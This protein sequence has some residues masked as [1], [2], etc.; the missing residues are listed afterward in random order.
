MTEKTAMEDDLKKALDESSIYSRRILALFLSLLVYV[1]ITVAST[2]D[3]DLLTANGRVM[4]PIVNVEIPIS[5]F[6]GVAPVFVLIFHFYLLFIFYKHSRKLYEWNKERK[7]ENELLLVPFIFNYYDPGKK[8]N[9][10]L[11]F[12]IWLLIYLLPLF[13]LIYIQWI[14]L[15]Y[16]SIGMNTYHFIAI[17]I[18]CLLIYFL[19]NKII[20]QDLS[21]EENDSFKINIKR[22]IKSKDILLLL[23]VV[24]SIVNIIY[25]TKLLLPDDDGFIY[26]PPESKDK[27]WSWYMRKIQL[28][29]PRETF[30]SSVP[31][32][33]IIQYYLTKGE[34]ADDARNE[35]FKNFAKGINL[36]NRDLRFAN[37]FKST[38]IN[39]DLQNAKLQGSSLRYATLQ[40]SDLS[41]AKLQGAHLRSAELQGAN[42]SNTNLENAVLR[43]A[44]LQ[45]DLSGVHSL[46]GADLRGAQLQGSIIRKKILQDVKYL[47]G[48]KLEGA[49]LRG[50]L[51]INLNPTDFSDDEFQNQKKDIKKLCKAIKNEGYELGMINAHENTIDWLNELLQ[52]TYLYDKVTAKKSD[53]PLTRHV[54]KLRE[55]TEKNRTRTFKNLKDDEQKA[56]K[57]LNRLMIE[58]AHPQETPNSLDLWSVQLQGAD[59]RGAYLTGDFSGA[60]LQGVDLRGAFI[61]GDLSSEQIRC[62]DLT[63]AIIQ[64]T[65]L[66]KIDIDS[67]S[68]VDWDEL[69]KKKSLVPENLR[70]GFVERINKAIDRSKNCKE[71]RAY[72]FQNEDEFIKARLELFCEQSDENKDSDGTIAEGIK[73]QYPLVEEKITKKI[74]EALKRKCL[75]KFDTINARIIENT[76]HPSS[77][78]PR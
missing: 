50:I 34:T 72:D 5:G 77:N 14:F 9:S 26:D 47:N 58:L 46:K 15:K 35:A 69:L 51:L 61:K 52:L 74:K 66:N 67:K 44:N 1:S 7:D 53:L 43:E 55:Q 70:E 36:K 37:F 4:L 56:L 16:H 13:V 27:E 3:L 45:T 75:A 73:M 22:L 68:K 28:E 59:L 65:Q 54:N 24:L 32:D 78:P 17:I 12:V 2:T 18:D 57:R 25:F 21:G 71:D 20:R 49:D 39:A 29:L 64:R 40:Y 60:Q 76:A 10:I 23:I 30:V 8:K 19:Y 33:E 38:F 42:M 63:G 6:F 48:A 62:A 31:G 41:S 11:R